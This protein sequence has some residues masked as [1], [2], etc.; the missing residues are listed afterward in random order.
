MTV[1]ERLAALIARVPRGMMLGLDR[2]RVACASLGDPQ[3]SLRCVHVAG[4]NGKGSTSAMVASIARAAG[5]SVGLY[6]SPHLVRFTERI[7]IDGAPI[8]DAS[9]ERAMG[10]VIDRCA[11][12]LTFFESVTLAA[13]VAFAEAK[14]DLAVLE[15]GLGGRLDATNVI[16][17]PVAT[18]VT[19]IGF[20]HQNYLG[21]TLTLIAREKAGIFKRGAPVVLGLLEPEARVACEAVAR[22]VGAGSITFADA[23]RVTMALGLAGEHQ[24]SNAAVAI[25]LCEATKHVFPRLADPSV[26]AAGLASTTWPGRL[27]RIDRDG[28]TVLLDCAHNPH[29]VEALARALEASTSRETTTL[30]FGALADK[31]FAPMLSRLAPLASQRVFTLP[32]GRAPAPIEVL[33]KLAP[34]FGVEEPREALRHAIALTPRGGVV[35]VTGS[36]YLVGALRAELL[37][38]VAD[39]MIAL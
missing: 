6:T 32:A 38:L 15:V 13:F 1:A 24:R 30:V 36:A 22:E 12:D 9:F 37:G 26:I 19:S 10:R 8:D 28:V 33:A 25:A 7:Q 14:V 31:D 29:G 2:V 16:D 5:L 39:P 20:D 27:E 35:V 21:D 23:S 18:A 17:S 34:G 4:T 3:A 11:P